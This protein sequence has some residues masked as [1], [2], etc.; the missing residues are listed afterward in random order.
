MRISVGCIVLG[1]SHTD[2][3]IARVRNTP[4]FIDVAYSVHRWNQ[5][6]PSA[7]RALYSKCIRTGACNVAAPDPVAL[8]PCHR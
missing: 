6:M 1:T 4:F 2:E 3:S 8:W 7:D 5:L